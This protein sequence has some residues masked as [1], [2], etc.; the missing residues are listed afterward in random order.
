MRV[1]ERFTCGQDFARTAGSDKNT[2]NLVFTE[3]E[4]GK[5][6]TNS[7][8]KMSGFRAIVDESFGEMI[9]QKSTPSKNEE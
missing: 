6:V 2:V 9:N 8:L 1:R 4:I 7:R 3:N 5:F